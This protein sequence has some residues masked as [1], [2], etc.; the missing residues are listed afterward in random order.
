MPFPPPDSVARLVPVDM[1]F[2]PPAP[3]AAAPAAVDA[4]DSPEDDGAPVGPTE[5]EESAFIAEERA[6]G[7][8]PAGAPRAPAA[9][10]E[11]EPAAPLPP[12]DELVNRIPEATR[13]L[14]DELFRARFVTVK[15][16]PRTALKGE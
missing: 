12:L 7:F 3:K 13:A 2:T 9:E 4:V 8:A 11:P 16:V 1:D 10:T 5:G 6:Q 14:M 15:R